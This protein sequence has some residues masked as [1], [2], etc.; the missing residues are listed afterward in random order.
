[1]KTLLCIA[2][3]GLTFLSA[4]NSE[5]PKTVTKPIANERDEITP[6]IVNK[7]YLLDTAYEAHMTEYKTKEAYDAEF[8][9]QYL[10]MASDP[11]AYLGDYIRSVAKD[12]ATPIYRDIKGQPMTKAEKDELF[13]LCDSIMGTSIDKQGIEHTSRFFACD[14]TSCY[15]FNYMI[16]FYESWYVNKKTR[17]LE[18][19]QLGFSTWDWQ[20]DKHAYRQLFT[21]F[22]N[23]ASRQKTLKYLKD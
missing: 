10:N 4:C 9:N 11:F 5:A 16:Q 14:S 6:F 22:K 15:Y 18:R 19:E 12:S 3:S 7:V 20:Q 17:Q 23:E 2:L 21:V 8:G 13:I 1:M